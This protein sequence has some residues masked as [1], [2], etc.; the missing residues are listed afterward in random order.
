MSILDS[1][2]SHFIEMV[3]GDAMRSLD[4]AEW[5]STIHFRPIMAMNGMP[6]GNL[7]GGSSHCLVR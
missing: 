6:G 5:D 4:V 3:N 7:G 1:A 2:K